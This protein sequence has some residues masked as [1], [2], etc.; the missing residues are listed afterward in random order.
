M[1]YLEFG[2]LRHRRVSCADTD[3]LSREGV[4]ELNAVPVMNAGS[5]QPALLGRVLCLLHL[6][7]PLQSRSTRFS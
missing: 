3:V 6:T 4:L 5:L 2:V 1:H 7:I